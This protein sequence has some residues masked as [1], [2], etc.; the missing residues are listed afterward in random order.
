MDDKSGNAFSKTS[1]QE[2][3]GPQEERKAAA[4]ATA[5]EAIKRLAGTFTS[6][7]TPHPSGLGAL[8]EPLGNTR[9]R[10]AKQSRVES[11]GTPAQNKFKKQRFSR[12][13]PLFRRRHERL[14]GISCKSPFAGPQ[15]NAAEYKESATT[16]NK[17]ILLTDQVAGRPRPSGQ[18]TTS[19]RS[20]RGGRLA[21]IF[22]SFS[23]QCT[24]PPT[25]HLFGPCSCG[26]T[27]RCWIP[28]HSPR[29]R[30]DGRK[31]D[32]RRCEQIQIRWRSL[33]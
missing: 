19:L 33:Q 8:I 11:T 32:R 22:F 14:A 29:H 23:P 16:Q 31:R 27:S 12:G 2:A 21:T 24:S 30:S 26:Q 9:I 13:N 3:A 10:S 4:A 28:R 15:E 25:N 17:I 7:R 1:C 20:C 6:T 18:N 5:G